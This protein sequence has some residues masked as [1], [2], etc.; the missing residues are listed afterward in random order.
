M[1]RWQ[2]GPGVQSHQEQAMKLGWVLVLLFLMER[3]IQ[4]DLDRK[5]L[6]PW[7]LDLP[8]EL[9]WVVLPE[10]QW[11]LVPWGLLTGVDWK[12]LQLDPASPL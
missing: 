3:G 7:V 1:T 6:F 10:K 11:D 9:D 12:W 4:W 5:R 2:L 8:S